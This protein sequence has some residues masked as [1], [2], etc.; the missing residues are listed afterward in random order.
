MV[1]KRSNIDL[2]PYK[3]KITT[4]RRKFRYSYM[5]MTFRIIP[6]IRKQIKSKNTFSSLNYVYNRQNLESKII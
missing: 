5:F 2:C 1:A 6:D 3:R 4:W